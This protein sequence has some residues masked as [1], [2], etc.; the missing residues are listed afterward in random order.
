MLHHHRGVAAALRMLQDHR[1]LQ[2]KRRYRK[3][4]R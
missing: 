4:V 3:P 1:L 2:G